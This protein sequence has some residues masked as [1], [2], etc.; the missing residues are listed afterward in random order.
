MGKPRDSRV[1]PSPP[2]SSI[3]GKPSDT[4]IIL[5]RGP[6]ADG[7]NGTTVQRKS[8]PGSSCEWY[9]TLTPIHLDVF[10]LTPTHVLKSRIT[11]DAAGKIQDTTDTQLSFSVYGG[12]AS[13]YGKLKAISEWR[14]KRQEPVQPSPPPGPQ[15]VLYGLQGAPR[16][17]A[18]DLAPP[19]SR[20]H[21]SFTMTTRQTP[22]AWLPAGPQGYSP[23]PKT[24]EIARPPPTGRGFTL[25]R[26]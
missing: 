16:R 24:Q 15:T 18:Y 25:D 22:A 7:P 19:C 21:P 26:V 4:R 10:F 2:S 3:M 8:P 12:D 17:T 13:S 23:H 11:K 1:T 6:V 14:S 9:P 5:E 20:Y